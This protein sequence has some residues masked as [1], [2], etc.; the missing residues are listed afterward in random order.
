MEI[1]QNNKK[2][3]KIIYLIYFGTVYSMALATIRGEI[4]SANEVILE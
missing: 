4:I 1:T 3:Q 2:I